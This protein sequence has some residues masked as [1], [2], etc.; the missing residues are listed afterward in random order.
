MSKIWKRPGE[1][2][3]AGFFVFRRGKSTGRISWGKTNHFPYEHPTFEAAQSE[4]ACLAEQNRGE[5]FA[6]FQ[7]VDA[8]KLEPENG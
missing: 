8:V 1:E 3:G 4:A 2:I 5:T 6:V 7:Q